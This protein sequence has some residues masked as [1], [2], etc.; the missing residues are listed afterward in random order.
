MPRK[1][2]VR[3]EELAREQAISVAD[4]VRIYLREA[5]YGGRD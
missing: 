5:L 4:L 3:L 2:K 1:W